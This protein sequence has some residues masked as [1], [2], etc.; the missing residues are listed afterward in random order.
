MPNVEALHCPNCGA[1]LPATPLAGAVICLYCNTVIRIQ[2]SSPTQSAQAVAERSMQAD[3]LDRFKQYILDGRKDEAARLYAEI[4]EVDPT[5]AARAV[6]TLE[7]GLSRDVI[8]HQQLTPTGWLIF[9][10]SMVL[11]LASLGLW[12][13]GRLNPWIAVILSLLA[14]ANLS[15]T[16]RSL[17]VSLEFLGAPVT[18]AR[19]LQLTR[20]GEVKFG[21]KMVH[22]L[23]LLLEIQPAGGQAYQAEM[24]LPVRDANL[25]RAAVGTT[26]R[27]RYRRDRPTR[28]VYQES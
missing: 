28:L 9:F 15:V 13:F 26:L 2:D 24:L 6:E 23:K 3:R 20:V 10:G 4:L 1:P 25:K 22:V 12:I 11:L 27:V 5:E 14:L 16:F 18:D 7:D 17:L 21:G 8:L 19:V